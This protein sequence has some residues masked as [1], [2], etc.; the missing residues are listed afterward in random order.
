MKGPV[1]PVGLAD[2]FMGFMLSSIALQF[3]GHPH[4]CTAYMSVVSE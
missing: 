4:E 1:F 3:G 2:Y